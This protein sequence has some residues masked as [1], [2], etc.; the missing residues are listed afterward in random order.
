MWVKAY[1]DPATFCDEEV[2]EPYLFRHTQGPSCTGCF[3]VDAR[4][5]SIV[6]K[7]PNCQAMGGLIVSHPLEIKTKAGVWQV[8]NDVTDLDQYA[9]CNWNSWDKV[10]EVS[11][12][13]FSKAPFHLLPN[14]PVEAQ[15][16]AI[17]NNG[18]ESSYITNNVAS[19]SC[20]AAGMPKMKQLPT[21]VQFSSVRAEKV[22]QSD[23]TAIHIKWIDNCNGIAGCHYEVVYDFV[24]SSSR[25][26]REITSSN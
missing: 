17:S 25:P 23:K 16:R 2:S 7:L 14:D 22:L 11:M 1:K 19:G 4:Q 15:T 6:F 3:E 8:L 21:Q 12:T 9:K 5:C 20:S 13:V 18:G 24:G 26:Q 10:C